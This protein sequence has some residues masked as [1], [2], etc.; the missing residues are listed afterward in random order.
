ME[1]KSKN[2]YTPRMMAVANQQP[3]AAAQL[4][5]LGPEALAGPDG[6]V[7]F[8]WM[9]MLAHPS[10][11][12]V[13]RRSLRRLQVPPGEVDALAARADRVVVV[14]QPVGHP[15][16]V[17]GPVV[18]VVADRGGWLSASLTRQFVRVGRSRTQ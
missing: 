11:A 10:G 6:S 18:T 8:G 5:A 9:L 17:I 15:E 1:A 12:P 16:K 14:V 7:R 4:T 13:T 2:G 3:E